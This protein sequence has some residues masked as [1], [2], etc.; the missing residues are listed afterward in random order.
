LTRQ[1][2]TL[3][4][5]IGKTTKKVLVFDDSFNVLEERTTSMVEI[6]DDDGFPA[7]DLP[8]VAKWFTSHLNRYLHHPEWD[9]TA[10]NVTAYG[11]SLVHLDE[12]GEVILPFYNYLKPFP[13]TCK[14]KFLTHYDPN[15]SISRETA[16]PFLGLLNS[17]LQLYWLK[18]EREK[19]FTRIKTSLHFPQYF[20]YLVTQQK[21]ADITSVG[22]HTLLWDMTK[23][24]YHSWVTAEGFE[25]LF[26]PVQPSDQVLT[27]EH[28]KR[29]IRVGIGVH[30]SSAALMPYLVTQHDPFLVLSTGTWNICFNPS[31]ATPL[32]QGELQKDCLCYMSYDGKPIKA[33][34]IFLGHEYELQ[35]KGLAEHFNKPV[36]FFQ[37]LQFNEEIYCRLSKHYQTNK[38]IYPL[39]LMGSGPIPEKPTAQTNLDAFDSPEEAYHQVLRYLVKW[40]HLSIDLVDP[41]SQVKNLLIVGGFT[42]NQVFLET[43]KRSSSKKIF[44][45]DHPRA[46]ALGAAWLVHGKDKYSGALLAVEPY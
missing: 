22:C 3:I 41:N 30:D 19:H 27:I 5:D 8:A 34:R 46:A 6:T 45:S 15:H 2:A 16:S 7:E 39:G 31:N 38:T 18:N 35:V 33:S 32:T 17:G 11:A 14:Q 25:K 1:P 9:I 21:C 36:E 29:I 26:P 28:E 23:N 13:E 43:L 40:Q 10:I 20:T 12:Q 4:F 24:N 42:K 44:L 37:H